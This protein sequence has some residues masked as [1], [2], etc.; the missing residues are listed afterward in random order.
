MFNKRSRIRYKWCTFLNLNVDENSNCSS[1]IAEDF[2]Q[3]LH[4]DEETFLLELDS[5]HF[6]RKVVPQKKEIYWRSAL[7]N[8]FIK[9]TNKVNWESYR[10]YDSKC[11]K[12]RQRSIKAYIEH[13]IRSGI[14]SNKPFW[15]SRRPFLT[16]KGTLTNNK[17]SLLRNRKTRDNE[18]QVAETLNNAY[19]NIGEHT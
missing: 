19:I 12:L 5:K 18:K 2:A 8:F 17:I 9:K 3:R 16:N 10:K 6:P 7:K 14:M 11:V 1:E 13:T 4:F 15:R